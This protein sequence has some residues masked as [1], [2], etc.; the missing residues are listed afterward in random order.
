MRPSISRYVE[1]VLEAASLSRGDEREV[2]EELASDLSEFEEAAGKVGATDG[3]VL[4]M[5]E[6]E[7]G[8]ADVL[9]AA[10]ARA[11]GRFR[12]YLKKEA[13]QLPRAIVVAAVLAAVLRW[14]VVAPY[15]V[16]SG[17]MDPV[18][19]DGSLVLVNQLAFRF[20]SPQAGDVVAY[21]E[22]GC[23]CLAQVEQVVEGGEAVVVRK[24]NPAASDSLGFPKTVPSRD[25][26]GRVWLVTR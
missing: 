11:K 1:A 22:R 4:A 19:S 3:E 24:S 9:G 13:R 8:K 20:D 18:L 12:T 26:F 14:Q 5:V 17:S 21:G 15:R 2:H 23:V 25:L 10:V 7:F 16:R 6:N